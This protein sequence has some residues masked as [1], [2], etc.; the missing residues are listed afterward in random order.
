MKDALI[1]LGRVNSKSLCPYTTCC[2][3]AYHTA[4]LKR[5]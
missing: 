4:V 5:C 2:V 3:S 1:S